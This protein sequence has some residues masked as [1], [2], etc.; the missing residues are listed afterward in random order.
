MKVEFLLVQHVSV[1][2]IEKE[3]AINDKAFAEFSA[4]QLIN[5]MKRGNES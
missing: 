1:K 2:L 5:L 3:Q 4:Q